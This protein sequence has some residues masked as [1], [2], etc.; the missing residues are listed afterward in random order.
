MATNQSQEMKGME[1][2]Y[3]IETNKNLT[4][5]EIFELKKLLDNFFEM[6]YTVTVS[7]NKVIYTEE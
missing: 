5:G 1:E 4:V 6:D 7:N 2:K 3:Y